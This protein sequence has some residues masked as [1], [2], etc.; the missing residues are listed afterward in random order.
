VYTVETLTTY[1]IN[2]ARP[3]AAVVAESLKYIVSNYLNCPSEQWLH[4]RK[5]RRRTRRCLC[6]DHVP[7]QQ[8]LN[9]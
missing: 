1:L 6:H 9:L 3:D 2:T 8:S 4:V 5:L 7:P